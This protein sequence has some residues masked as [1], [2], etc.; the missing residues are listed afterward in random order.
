MLEHR[1]LVLCGSLASF[2]DHVTGRLNLSWSYREG[3]VVIERYITE[4]FELADFVGTQDF[5]QGYSIL[6]PG[7]DQTPT[8][9]QSRFG[10]STATLEL[11]HT[12]SD[13]AQYRIAIAIAMAR[14]LPPTTS[15]A[16]CASTSR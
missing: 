14:C 2:L 11:L 15:P 3:V 1:I 5:K 9:T 7:A 13:T 12:M 16:R 4:N 8:K 10:T 6:A